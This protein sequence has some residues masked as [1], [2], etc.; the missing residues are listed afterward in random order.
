MAL[1]SIPSHDVPVINME[2][3]RMTLAWY[4][5]F[6]LRDQIRLAD[7]RDVDVTGIADGEVLAWVEAD[8]K[9]T[10]DTN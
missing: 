2:T 6:K 4:Q 3:G 1:R 8:E 7:M 9:F 5:Y 10:P